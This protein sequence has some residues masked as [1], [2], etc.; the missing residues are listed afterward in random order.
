[1][2]YFSLFM[3]PRGSQSGRS[4]PL[5]VPLIN[6][7]N[8]FLANQRVGLAGGNLWLFYMK[9]VSIDQD[10]RR[11]EERITWTQGN[12]ICR[13][14]F[15][16]DFL[17]VYRKF[18]SLMYEISTLLSVVC[19][20]NV[21]MY[22]Q[23]EKQ[24]IML[25]PGYYAQHYARQEVIMLKLCRT[26]MTLPPHPHKPVLLINIPGVSFLKEMSDKNYSVKHYYEQLKLGSLA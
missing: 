16:A 11:A 25:K 21:I 2:I 1:M 15:T 23:L 18:I 9:W 24:S 8:I 5:R 12:S 19:E 3:G 20:A 13:S 17:K 7:K 4:V 22:M 6:Q 26:K 14:V 10:S